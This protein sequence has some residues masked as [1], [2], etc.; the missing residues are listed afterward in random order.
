MIVDNAIA[1]DEEYK[2]FVFSDSYWRLSKNLV[3]ALG[4]RDALWL[5]D[6][7]SK[8]QL[9]QSRELVDKEGWFYS[10]RRFI[11][12]STGIP[13][14]TQTVI[15]SRLVKLG[16]IQV[17]RLGVP[18]KNYYRISFRQMV[19]LCKGVRDAQ[20]PQFE[21]SGVLNLGTQES[22]KSGIYNNK[23]LI[24]QDQKSVP[25]G[26]TPTVATSSPRRV[27]PTLSF[28]DAEV[29]HERR[30]SGAITE[31]EKTKLIISAD[32]RDIIQHWNTKDKIFTSHTKLETKGMQKI[33]KIL[34]G[35]LLPKFG[36][37]EI[38]DA[39]DRAAIM[40][41]NKGSF[42]KAPPYKMRLLD[43]L[44][45]ESDKFK[46][47][48]G[49][50]GVPWFRRLI[51][52]NSHLKFIKERDRYPEITKLLKDA[53]WKHTTCEKTQ[54][55]P[56]QEIQFRLAAEKLHDY[57]ANGDRLGEHIPNATTADYVRVLYEALVH[58][59]GD[60]KDSSDI[61]VGNLCSDYT[62][63]NIFPRY[64]TKMYL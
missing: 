28:D 60:D 20:S 58:R 54:L 51:G 26:T 35:R 29:G 21:D 47:G 52:D 50:D 32:A 5:T 13:E 7:L 16:I 46:R 9:L 36:Y 59:L 18:A 12:D 64:L 8:Y 31:P 39:I 56:K 41:H 38:R 53:Y 30:P 15:I 1:M 42:T 22:S 61:E 19:L 34:D 48:R 24:N 27:R 43:F 4:F 57:R 14:K 49:G 3:K 6:L 33:I 55:S 23:D 11:A 62:W 17:K 45:A 25:I 44:T 63:N 10:L 2:Q 40:A 37:K